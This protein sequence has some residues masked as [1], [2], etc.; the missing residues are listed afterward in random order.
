M[1]LRA[2]LVATCLVLLDLFQPANGFSLGGITRRVQHTNAQVTYT[3]HISYTH[4]CTH[5]TK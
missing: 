3:V 4:K 1:S 2:L 5:H